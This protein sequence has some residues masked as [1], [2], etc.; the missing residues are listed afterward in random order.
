MPNMSKLI[1]LL[2]LVFFNISPSIS[3]EDSEKLLNP[4]FSFDGIFGKFDRASLQRGYQV[5]SEVC[6]ACHSMSLLNYRNLSQQGGP[7][8]TEEETKAIASKFEVEDGPNQNGEMFK[9][10]SKP[11]DHFKSPFPNEQAARAANG[12]AYPPDMST[13]AKAR[14][15]GPSYIYSILLGYEKSPKN[16]KLEDGVYYNKFKPGNSIK[17]PKPLN[18][19]AVKYS[20]GTEAS[21]EQ[22]ALDV[23]TFLTWASDPH[24]EERK[25]TGF[26]TIIFL[27]IVSALAYFVKK[28]TWSRIEPKM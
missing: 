23:T 4:K 12:G 5:Y 25:K 3:A 24:L 22:M 18:K 27:L 11:S 8:F 19:D 16:I 10:S 15:G 17:M 6:S 28:K 1:L 26:K 14:E 13:L 2:F 20:D 9:R 7:E 21:V